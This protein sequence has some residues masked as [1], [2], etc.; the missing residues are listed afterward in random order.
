MNITS[1]YG[2][3]SSQQGYVLLT[4][5]LLVALMTITAAVV[6]AKITTEIQ[7]DREEE[8]IHRATEYRRAIS[9][10]TKKS[11]RFPMTLDDLDH[12]SGV[13]YLRRRY[14]DPITGKDFRLLRMGDIA[15]FTVSSANGLQP[16]AGQN[17]SNSSPGES[18][19]SSAAGGQLDGANPE[20]APQSSS[21]ADSSAGLNPQSSAPGSSSDNPTLGGG[22]LV[23][24][25]STSP[26]KTIREFNSKNH[27]NQWFFFYDPRF[28]RGIDIPGPTQLT[29]V[30]A[31]QQMPSSNST[32]AVQP[33][34]T[35]PQS[36]GSS[37]QQ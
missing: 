15:A 13:R 1:S 6:A 18:P 25:V 16:G 10:F 22:V 30:P 24:V 4:L 35:S 12:T 26:K 34:S 36:P 11:G 28:D 20:A 19:D 23:G 3:K 5:L 7:R 32:G 17:G 37:S 33:Q 9:R 2:R 21:E 14:K 29:M 8:L 31:S 27:Y